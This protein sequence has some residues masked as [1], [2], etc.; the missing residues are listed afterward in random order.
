MDL[1]ELLLGDSDD[2]NKKSKP[3]V[4]DSLLKDNMSILKPSYGVHQKNIEEMTNSSNEPKI[5]I[6]IN[7]D[8]EAKNQKKE[9]NNSGN[10]LANFIFGNE[11]IQKNKF[12]S[13]K[14]F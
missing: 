3:K 2:E 8:N 9:E 5:I 7:E 13:I 14:F 10:A 12:K 1:D 6:P 11:P 4:V